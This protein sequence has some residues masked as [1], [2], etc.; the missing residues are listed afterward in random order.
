VVAFFPLGRIVARNE[1]NNPKKGFHLL[2]DVFTVGFDDHPDIFTIRQIDVQSLPV[3]G[4]W[5]ELRSGW[6]EFELPVNK[7]W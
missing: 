2:T 3:P 5:S 4:D 6:E 7:A 1:W